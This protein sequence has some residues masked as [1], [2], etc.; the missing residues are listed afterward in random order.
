M[1]E[2]YKIVFGIYK[3]KA[4]AERAVDTFKADGFRSSDIS[5]LVPNS[6][7]AEAPQMVHE[8]STKAP[9][10]AITGAGTGVVI[11]GALGWLLG[12]GVI[13]IPGIGPLLAAG[14]LVAALAGA[15]IVGTVGGLS[16][17]LIGVGIPEYEAK[18]YEGYLSKG[19]VL[20]S[21]HADNAEWVS[22]AK[23]IL[24]MT[25]ASDISTSREAEPEWKDVSVPPQYNRIPN[26]GIYPN[27]PIL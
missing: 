2:N 5:V 9:E 27:T 23:H 24:D 3:M 12:A 16:G 11:G 14:P 8:N 7:S 10:G 25:G 19:G 4:D 13:A 20:L 21:V 15:G 6:H 17:A 22:K 18:R 1:K 26:T